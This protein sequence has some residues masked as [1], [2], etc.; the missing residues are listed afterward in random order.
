MIG[1]RKSAQTHA[2][3]ALSIIEPLRGRNV[4]GGST[5]RPQTGRFHFHHETCSPT[6][7]MREP[8]TQDTTRNKGQQTTINIDEVGDREHGVFL[9]V[10]ATIDAVICYSHQEPTLTKLQR[11]SSYPPA[12]QMMNTLTTFRSAGKSWR[13]LARCGGP[14]D[15]RHNQT[16]NNS[17]DNKKQRVNRHRSESDGAWTRRPHTWCFFCEPANK[18]TQ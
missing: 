18:S 13:D 7:H 11:V 14:V 6:N 3:S 16:R 17:R 9:W 12:R 5:E 8:T 2:H 1:R 4:N 15:A 10:C